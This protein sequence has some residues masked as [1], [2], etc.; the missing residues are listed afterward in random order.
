M[1]DSHKRI[2]LCAFIK[3]GLTDG[4]APGDWNRSLGNNR[5]LSIMEG[6]YTNPTDSKIPRRTDAAVLI[7]RCRR[8][9]ADASRI[10]IRSGRGRIQ[11]RQRLP[12]PSVLTGT[13][14]NAGRKAGCGGFRKEAIGCAGCL[15]EQSEK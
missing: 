5:C 4:S 11:S 9:V 15:F 2:R 12:V 8:P 3:A 10:P 6:L 7:R 1:V 13:P 14:M